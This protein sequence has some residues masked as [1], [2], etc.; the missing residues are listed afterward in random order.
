MPTKPISAISVLATLNP[1]PATAAVT[2]S[3][4]GSNIT[5]ILDAVNTPNAAGLWGLGYQA[6]K[7]VFKENN[8]MHYPLQAGG[9]ADGHG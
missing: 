7:K 9:F 3:A 4:N 5:A 1:S 8:Q 2:I 6:Q